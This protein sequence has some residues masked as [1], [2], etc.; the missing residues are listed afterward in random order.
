MRVTALRRGFYIKIREPGDQFD[1]PASVFSPN[2]MAKGSVDV[3][4]DQQAPIGGAP[5]AESE[6]LGNKPK[7]FGEEVGP[8]AAPVSKKVTK[9][10]R[11]GRPRK[12][13][14]SA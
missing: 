9:K 4:V 14:Q 1:C 6:V 8:T 2:W 3:E 11:R 13:D 10:K 12:N 7:T 5:R